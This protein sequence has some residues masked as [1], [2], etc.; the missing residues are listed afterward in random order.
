MIVSIVG[1]INATAFLVHICYVIG[2]RAK[3]KM[4]RVDATP[5]IASMTDMKTVTD[6]TFMNLVGY[7]MSAK[8]WTATATNLT[9]ARVIDVALPLPTFIGWTGGYVLPEQN[10]W[11]ASQSMT[12]AKSGVLAFDQ[13]AFV[14]CVLGYWRNLAAATLAILRGLI[15]GVFNCVM[16]ANKSDWFAYRPSAFLATIRR[17]LRFLPASAMTKTVGDFLSGVRGG[18]IIHSDS[19][20]KTVV[21]SGGI[22]KMLPGLFVGLTGVII[23]QISDLYKVV[24]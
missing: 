24:R 8:K 22:L 19:P 9:I 3:P 23:A 15:N 14:V 17:N 1:R 21:Q 16:T 18:I 20:P 13:A 7:T 5:I 2:I 6:F 12:F 10:I 11:G 4:I